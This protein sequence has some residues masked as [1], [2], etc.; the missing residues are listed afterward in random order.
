MGP[1]VCLDKRQKKQ[2][3]TPREEADGTMETEI[4]YAAT[5]QGMPKTAGSH[6][7]PGARP[8]TVSPSEPI[9]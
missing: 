3:Q 7:K 4:S 5:S 6:Q 9:H 8:G 2:T 1:R